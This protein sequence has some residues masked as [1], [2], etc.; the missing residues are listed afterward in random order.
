MNH[1]YYAL[2]IL[3]V[4]C[5][6]CSLVL[7][8]YLRIIEQQPIPTLSVNKIFQV[9][10][11]SGILYALIIILGYLFTSKIGFHAFLF[12]R[13]DKNLGNELLIALASGTILGC[14]LLIFDISVL[15]K[16]LFQGDS[17]PS[18]LPNILYPFL[19][20]FYGAINEEVIQRFFL[21]PLCIFIALK[22]IK[23]VSATVLVYLTIIVT[24]LIF[25]IL[26][27]PALTSLAPISPFSILRLILL[28]T[29]AGILFGWLF[30]KK[31][32]ESAMVAHFATDIVIQVL[33]RLLLI[34]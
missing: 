26:H 32:I 12:D 4:C 30:W 1:R 21:L 15:F 17:C 2:F 14:V 7:F 16:P 24:S 3:W 33:P 29:V 19:A 8:P 25:G 20:S 13:A 11:Q 23:G 27:L 10:I 34:F 22:T 5:I 28:N 18:L 9:M 6:L 31:G